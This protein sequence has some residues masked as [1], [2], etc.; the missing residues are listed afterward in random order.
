M[1]CNGRMF[2]LSFEHSH[3]LT[4]AS[5][6]SS[7][8][9]AFTA[10]KAAQMDPHETM[11]S[12]VYKKLFP[13]HIYSR[14]PKGD[15]SE[16]VTLT[17]Q[18]IV[19]YYVKY[20]HP[21]NGQAFCFGK[22]EFIDTCLKELEP[23][24]NEYE[25]NEGIRHNSKIEWQDMTELSSEE[26]SIGY[27]SWQDQVDYR[28]IVAWVLND[29]PM[30]MRT[31][32]SWHLLYELLVGSS[33]GPIPKAIIDLN[34]GDDFVTFFDSSLQQWVMALGVSGIVSQDKVEVARSSIDGKL[35]NIVNQGFEKGALDAALNKIE[36]KVRETIAILSRLALLFL[37]PLLPSLFRSSVNKAQQICHEV[38]KLSRKCL[39]TGTTTET[40]F[41]HCVIPRHLQNSRLKSKRM[42]RFGFWNF[43]RVAC[44]TTSTQHS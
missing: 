29:E 24:L 6:T 5:L 14:D 10:A 38:S 40:L 21:A 11:I 19:D 30:D 4:L 44:L 36:F 42:A 35:R 16:I 28:S 22:Q 3:S 34:L 8:R 23:A 27:P 33:S 41:C 26:Q 7:C 43:L 1:P 39:G 32:I 15:A 9:N 17:Y 12:Q 25:Y 37:T 31:Q 13:D 18:K 2:V 20:Y